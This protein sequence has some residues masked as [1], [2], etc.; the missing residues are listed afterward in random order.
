LAGAA[1]AAPSFSFGDFRFLPRTGEL[2][3][4]EVDVK[5]TP[6]AAAVLAVLVHQSGQLVTKQELLDEVWKA[7][8]V[9]DE[10]LTSCIQELRR[11]V[12]DDARQPR[13]IETRY[14]RGYRLL[15]PVG[16]TS[17]EK[18]SAGMPTVRELPDKPSIAVLPFQ[19][20]SGDADQDY[21]ADGVVEEI[22]T[23]LSRFRSLF[24]I[25]R[26]SSFT[27]K[28]QEVDVRQVGRELGVRYV[29][30]G[31]VRKAGGRV[32]IIV[33]LIACET[34]SHLWAERY[35]GDLADIFDLQDKVTMDVV[36]AITPKLEQAEIARTRRKPTNRMDAYEIHLRAM[37]CFYS[38]TLE[39]LKEAQK[40]CSRAMELDP[41]FALPLAMAAFLPSVL[42][43][44]GLT[45]DRGTI[46]EVSLARRAVELEHDDPVVLCLAAWAQAL[47]LRD[48]DTA[49]DLVER[50]LVL[51]PNLALA[52][53][54]SGWVQMW[55][56]RP[57]VGKERFAQAMRLSPL[58]LHMPRMQTGAA[59]AQFMAGSYDEAMAL[60]RRALLHWQASPPYRIA[61]ASGALAGQL[62]EARRYMGRFLELDPG[63]RLSNLL[64]VMGP[65]RRPEDL[66]RYK[67]G[68]RLAGL[69]E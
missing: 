29:L 37:A 57:D 34:E 62:Q 32:R 49:S 20:M 2:W 11:A 68:L 31:S 55:L 7:S 61:A 21:F 26:N 63:R 8:A 9:G 53:Q 54:F 59:H 44:R 10:A 52:R 13:Y 40:F 30:E 67:E 48:L 14:R 66:S 50:A 60:A 15:A 51:N 46:A 38:G 47:T 18:R 58:D 56:G 33:Q 4:G 64:E 17:M 25:A 41:D 3:R 45:L 42:V 16:P 5:L 1:V 19:N 24:V 36:G 6:R 23:A 43:S 28:A 12:G 27:Y 39:N 35:D 69:P 22:I 65:Y